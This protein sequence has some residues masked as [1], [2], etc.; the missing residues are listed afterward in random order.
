MEEAERR[1]ARKGLIENYTNLPE[2]G[3][4][5]LLMTLFIEKKRRKGKAS[6][7]GLCIASALV[8]VLYKA[9]QLPPWA[10]FVELLFARHTAKEFFDMW[11]VALPFMLHVLVVLCDTLDDIKE[12]ES[13]DDENM[14]WQEKA[15]KKL[16]EVIA[17]VLLSLG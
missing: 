2:Y 14:E 11:R 3:A 12:K 5:M 13:T 4:W 6:V 16:D 10:L 7:L 1:D 15:T 17:C 8:E 9:G